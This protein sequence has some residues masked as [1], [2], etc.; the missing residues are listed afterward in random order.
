MKY[1]ITSFSAADLDFPFIGDGHFKV[2]YIAGLDSADK[3]CL[4][5]YKGDDAGRLA[6]IKADILLTNN[7]FK[8]QIEM[9]DS[10]AVVFCE[11]PKFEF[12]KILSQNYQT[13]FEYE[14][15]PP[16]FDKSVNTFLNYPSLKRLYGY[17]ISGG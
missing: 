16:V 6:E 9:S 13:S 4:T 17:L 7:R 12:I 2:D 14:G 1:K 3:T 11:N 8:G 10:A 5:H 15:Q